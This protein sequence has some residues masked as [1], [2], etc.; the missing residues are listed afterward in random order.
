MSAFESKRQFCTRILARL[1]QYGDSKATWNPKNQLCASLLSK[2]II[3]TKESAKIPKCFCEP[4]SNHSKWT[5][6]EKPT[7][8]KTQKLASGF[9]LNW[10][11]C[12][13]VSFTGRFNLREVIVDMRIFQLL[14]IQVQLGRQWRAGGHVFRGKDNWPRR[15]N[16][17][18]VL[19]SSGFYANRRVWVDSKSCVRPLGSTLKGCVNLL[20]RGLN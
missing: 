2:N 7:V 5:I 11:G 14:I 16:A 13:S 12:E 20:W 8:D 4:T 1:S 18:I 3:S 15:N 6:C 10:K 9:G 17:Q 19:C